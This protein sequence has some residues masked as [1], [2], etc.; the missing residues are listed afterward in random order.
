MFSSR[1]VGWTVIGSYAV[2]VHNRASASGLSISEGLAGL[3]SS[4]ECELSSWLKAGSL[5][6]VTGKVEHR[7]VCEH[8]HRV[9]KS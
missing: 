9:S 5:Q 7:E 2:C 6:E 4:A 3:V 8:G 1:R